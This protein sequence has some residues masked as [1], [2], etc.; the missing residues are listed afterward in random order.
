MS[1]N[2]PRDT[3]VKLLQGQIAD[4]SA[5][6]SPREDAN[7]LMEDIV[8]LDG[9]TNAIIVDW[10]SIIYDNQSLQVSIM[11]DFAQIINNQTYAGRNPEHPNEVVISGML[12]EANGRKIGDTI[13]LSLGDR[14][15]EYIITGFFQSTNNLGRESLLTAEGYRLLDPY[16]KEGTIIISMTGDADVDAFVETLELR[17]G[18]KLFN[19]RNDREFMAMIIGP[20][21]AG[22]HIMSVMFVI[23]NALIIVFILFL[24][25]RTLIMRRKKELGIQKAIGFTTFQL[26]NQMAL[27][28]VPVAIVGTAIGSFATTLTL[29]D[30]VGLLLRSMGIMKVD[31]IIPMPIIVT[32]PVLICVLTYAVS[33]LVSMRI[34]KISAYALITE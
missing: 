18:E 29:N 19:I 17:Y 30:S 21:T 33:M 23:V 22:I 26:M 8:K 4:I 1:Y 14:Y 13:T 31:Y 12:G 25:V 20:I 34:K 32:A 28:F 9:V 11:Q 16:Y 7:E 24:V 3:F 27:S 10:R 5:S 2:A 15:E 6:V